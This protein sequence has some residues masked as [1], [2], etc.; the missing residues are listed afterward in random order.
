[1]Q[2]LFI[3]KEWKRLR[4]PEAA[5]RVTMKKGKENK[6]RRIG[7]L[8]SFALLIGEKGDTGSGRSGVHPI[9]AEETPFDTIR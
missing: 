4:N 6:L 2:F 9:L 5:T 1:M 7:C 8:L 3:R